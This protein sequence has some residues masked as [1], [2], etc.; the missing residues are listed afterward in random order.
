MSKAI[1]S[2]ILI[3]AIA[4]WP[5]LA[6]RTQQNPASDQSLPVEKVLVGAYDAAHVN[7]LVFI[8]GQQNAIE[9]N[10]FGLRFIVSQSGVAEES[11]RKFEL[12]QHAPDGSFAKVSWQ[13]AFDPKTTITLR[14]SRAGKHIVV[15]QLAS[16]A[17]VR[18]TVEAYRPWSDARDGLAWP[19]FHELE[20]HRTIWANRF[21]T[22]KTKRR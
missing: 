1:L 16:S 9:Q 13:P 7:G 11:P 22:R 3:S 15:G 10:C 20:D 2:A 19:S 14:W 6:A 17:N 18:L 5:P 8:T 21:I 12:G 4:L